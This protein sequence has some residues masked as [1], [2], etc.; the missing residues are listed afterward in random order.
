MEIIG[1][2]N[3]PEQL[4][5]KLGPGRR[6]SRIATGHDA[7]SLVNVSQSHVRASQ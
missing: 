6:R 1:R 3:S 5:T 7:T 2:Y 4:L